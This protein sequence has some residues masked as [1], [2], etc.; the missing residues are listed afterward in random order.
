MTN[1]MIDLVLT[2]LGGNGRRK[3]SWQCDNG[4]LLSFR[5]SHPTAPVRCVD[6]HARTAASQYTKNHQWQLLRNLLTSVERANAG[7]SCPD[8]ECSHDLAEEDPT[9]GMTVLHEV[10]RESDPPVDVVRTVAR[11]FPEMVVARDTDAGRCPLHL[12]VEGRASMNVVRSL[13]KSNPD[14]IA[15]RDDRGMTALMLASELIGRAAAAAGA[16]NKSASSGDAEDVV[17]F[18]LARPSSSRFV[19]LE[20]KGGRTA[21]EIALMREASAAVVSEL[22]Q[23]TKKAREEEHRRELAS[24]KSSKRTGSF[25]IAAKRKLSSIRK[26]MIGDSQ[27]RMV[28]ATSA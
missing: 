7:C 21:L 16:S 26:S 10:C 8:S 25:S 1:P 19:L 11:L 14:C 4:S 6:S 12:A 24:R 5:R 3:R 27:I 18:L 15:I 22:Q 28:A 17:E 13:A 23:C 9:T 2:K 20:D